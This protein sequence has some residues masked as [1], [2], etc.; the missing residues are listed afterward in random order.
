M[1][2]KP[3][4]VGAATV[5]AADVLSSKLPP[6][7]DVGGLPVRHAGAAFAGAYAASY[8]SGGQPGLMK[9][10]ITAVVALISAELATKVAP[11]TDYMVGPVSVKRAL[12]GAAGAWGAGKFLK[13]E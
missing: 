7:I 5:V 4:I 12:A 11:A 9:T 13:A 8:A 3:L 1:H 6:S 10:A 2:Y